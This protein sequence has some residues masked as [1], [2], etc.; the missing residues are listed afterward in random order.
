MTGIPLLLA[1]VAAAPA[2]NNLAPTTWSENYTKALERTQE[3][4]KPLLVVIHDPADAKS[5]SKHATDKPD[6]TQAQLLKHY[7]LC[8][9]DGTTE[10]G[11][12]VADAFQVES[13]P[14]MAVIDKTGTSVLCRHAGSLEVDQWVEKLVAH[15]DGE[16]PATRTAAAT[17]TSN[18]NAQASR[19]RSYR[20]R[21]RRSTSSSSSCYT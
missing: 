13:L 15:K 18:S 3:T 17:S 9:I 5:R 21:G 12:K 11:K 1:F 6:A 8:R 4:E 16:I 2:A 7:E 20:S 10:Y 14:F 19:G